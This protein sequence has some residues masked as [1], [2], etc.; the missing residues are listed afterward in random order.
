MSQIYKLRTET[1]SV[2]SKNINN[3]TEQKKYL[4]KNGYFNLLTRT[5]LTKLTIR[6]SLHK[7]KKRVLFDLALTLNEYTQDQA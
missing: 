5:I 2:R 4:N 1:R 7:V 6:V 3:A